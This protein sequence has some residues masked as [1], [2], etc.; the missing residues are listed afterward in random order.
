MCFCVSMFVSFWIFQL[1]PDQI[2]DFQGN[3][4]NYLCLKNCPLPNIN[5]RKL[6]KKV[7]FIMW[8]ML[9]CNPTYCLEWDYWICIKDYSV[10]VVLQN[11]GFDSKIVSH[12]YSF[13]CWRPVIVQNMARILSKHQILSVTLLNILLISKYLIPFKSSLPQVTKEVVFKLCT[14]LLLLVLS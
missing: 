12:F 13:E 5:V 10:I 7:I 14:Y 1:N 8:T 2:L 9:K 4:P 3:L 11:C 6:Q